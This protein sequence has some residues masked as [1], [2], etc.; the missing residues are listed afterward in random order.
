MSKLLSKRF[1]LALGSFITAVASDE[2][3]AAISIVVAYL[4]ADTLRPSTSVSGASQSDSEGDG[5]AP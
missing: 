3:G 2:W 5:T 1:L 4:G